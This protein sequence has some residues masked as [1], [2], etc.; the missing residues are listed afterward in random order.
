MDGHAV[1]RAMRADAALSGAFLVALTGYG[2]ADDR[3]RALE[4]G[5]DPHLTKPISCEQLQGLFLGIQEP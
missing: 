1:A 4:A 2:Q 5:F 3:K